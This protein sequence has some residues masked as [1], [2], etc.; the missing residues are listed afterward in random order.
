MK[1]MRALVN[2]DTSTSFSLTRIP[3][4]SFSHP[5]TLS[6][7]FNTVWNRS[8]ESGQL[9]FGVDLTVNSLSLLVLNVPGIL[10]IDT[11]YWEKESLFYS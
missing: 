10:P 9:Y 8:V 6:R 2:P 1:R 3:F 7:I 11:H 5:L 4:I